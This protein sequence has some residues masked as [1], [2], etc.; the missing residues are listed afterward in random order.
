MKQPLVSVI[1]PTYR[2]AYTLKYALEGLK[3]QTYKNFE[4]VVVFKPGGDETKKILKDYGKDLPLRVIIQ[5]DSFITNAYNLGL[6]KANGEIIAFLDDDAVPYPNWLEEHVKTYHKYGRV[7]G[8]S[9]PA[10]SANIT[11]DGRIVQ[12]P[13]DSVY[14][15][16]KQVKYYDFPWSR[17][18]TGMS[19]WLIYFGRDGLVH[20]RQLLRKGNFKGIFPSL[21]FMG[22]NMSVKRDAIEGLR[23]DESLILGFACEQRFSYQ[24]W[25]RGYKLLYNT[26]AR[27]L[28]I[29]HGESLGRFFQ[30]PKRAALRDA[31]FVLTFPL[32]RSKEK[33]VS[34]PAYILGIITL[35]VGR[36]LNGRNYGFSISMYRIYGLRYGSVVGYASLVSKALGGKFSIRNSLSALLS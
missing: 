25:R 6:K 30:K 17:P 14:P 12:V 21:L 16:S 5:K 19:D 33:E 9:G 18:L 28:H 26:N 31:E 27:V 20:H 7:G 35:I 3:G 36:M 24:I 13:E 32:L 29:V 8:V 2:R 1:I 22:A 10:E 4:V 15:Y 34:W 23:M 11:K